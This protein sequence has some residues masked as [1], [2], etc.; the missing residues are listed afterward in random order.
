ML[1]LRVC[2]AMIV[3]LSI[4]LNFVIPT[5]KGSSVAV[6]KIAAIEDPSCVGMTKS[7]QSFHSIRLS[8]VSLYHAVYLLQN[9]VNT[10]ER[11]D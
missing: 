7:E 8:Y 4:R 6:P 2:Y 1:A 9:Y 5:Q 3:F 10:P 11:A